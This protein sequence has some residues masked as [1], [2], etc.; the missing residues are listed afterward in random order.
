V[1]PATPTPPLINGWL[2][3]FHSAFDRRYVALQ[4][5]ARELKERLST[6]QYAQ[7]PRVMLLAAVTRLIA[8]IVPD[9]PNAPDFRLHD[10]LS[11]CR[12]AKGHGLPQRYRLFWVF[13][14]RN[15]TIIFLYLN[16]EETLRK[17]GARS[18]PYAVFARL[19]ARGEIGADFA[20][21]LAA[22][23][24]HAGAGSIEGPT[25]PADGEASGRSRSR[26]KPPRR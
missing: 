5:E 7:H 13:S 17:E 24:R 15:K 18:D 4:G 21:N 1:P 9:D 19:V 20:A 23:Q 14:E 26:R 2:V 22:W 10:E 12:R 3:L 6:Q 11:T 16:D 25:S 8:E